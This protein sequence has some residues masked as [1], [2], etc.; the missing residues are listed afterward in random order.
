MTCV[1][2]NNL[3]LNKLYQFL[4]KASQ[5]TWAS[6]GENL[7][8]PERK[9]FSEL[10]FQEGDWF[11]KDSFAGSMR[12]W[13]TELIRFQGKPVWNC[14]YGGGMVDGKDSMADETYVFLKGALKLPHETLQSARG[15]ETF[16]K[17]DWRYVYQQDGDISLFNGYEEIFY[18]DELVHF[19]RTLG[20]MIR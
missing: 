5:S 11:Y 4:K 2:M 20:G 14:V 10:D 17:G 6:N 7:D 9:D 18:K 13:G 3:N 12:S 15:P 19:Y 1:T 8:T 16:E